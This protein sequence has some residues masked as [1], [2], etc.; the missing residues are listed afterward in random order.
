MSKLL[1]AIIEGMP[2]N[3]VEGSRDLVLAN[4]VPVSTTNRDNNA[5]SVAFY[6]SFDPVHGGYEV[7]VIKLNHRAPLLDATMVKNAE[8]LY[9][10]DAL[11]HLES[12][13]KG[14]V[15]EMSEM[16]KGT[17]EFH[18]NVISK[19]LIIEKRELAE[20]NISEITNLKLKREEMTSDL[21]VLARKT[22]LLANEESLARTHIATLTVQNEKLQGNM[23]YYIK[24]MLQNEFNKLQQ[25]ITTIQLVRIIRKTTR[26][27]SIIWL[28]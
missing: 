24:R 20:R 22:Q 14:M 18:Y 13:P 6:H 21:L 9:R 25:T 15:N 19:K 17:L 10:R 2:S 27:V 5:S 7:S 4:P 11:L 26:R 12:F 28:N 8:L 16:T 23:E 3:K 1:Q